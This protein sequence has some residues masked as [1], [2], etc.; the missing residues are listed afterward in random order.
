MLAFHSL[1]LAF[2]G[3]GSMAQNLI[4]GYLNQSNIK[5]KNIFISGRDSQKAHKLSNQLKVHA[6]SDNEELLEQ[7][8]I[9][10]LCIKPQDGQKTIEE[11]CHKWS[12]KQTVLSVMAG[13]S[14]KQLK[15]WGLRIK[16]LIRLMPNTNVCMGQGLLPF[17]SL[18]NQVNLNGFIEEILRPLGMVL[19]LEEEK[20]LDPLTVA[21]A[22]GSSFVLEIMSYWEEWLNGEGFSKEQAKKLTLKTFLG[23]CSM[24]EKRISKSFSELQQEI[25]SKKGISHAGLKNLRE[26]EM[27]RVLRL[28]FEQAQL[29][30]NEIHR[31]LAF[32]K[33]V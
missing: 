29:R 13:V 20:L 12:D 4:K 28:S 1:K 30:L 33:K 7:A 31:N 24:A 19:V 21:C 26:L 11:L 17:C 15:K 32:L 25:V 23:T 22:S 5:S 3:A 2:L 27:E 10:F 9:I 16:R 6:L 18:N 8:D 14:F